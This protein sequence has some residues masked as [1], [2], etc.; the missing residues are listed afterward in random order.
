MSL[1]FFGCKRADIATESQTEMAPKSSSKAEKESKTP[2]VS[3]AAA[4]TASSK[5][6]AAKPKKT[7][8]TV[9]HSPSQKAGIAPLSA[10]GSTSK[11]K[12][13]SSTCLDEAAPAA[14]RRRL[15]RRDTNDKVDRALK[16][17]AHGLPQV[18]VDGTRNAEG[19]TMR[20]KC[21]RDIKGNDGK[22]RLSSK[23][24]SD[25]FEEFGVGGDPFSALK[26]QDD[27]QS[28]SPAL[29]GAL[30]ALSQRNPC[31][32]NSKPLIAYLGQTASM[33]QREM[34]GMLRMVGKFASNGAKQHDP[35]IL[36]VGAFLAKL[37]GRESHPEACACVKTLLDSALARDWQ[38]MRRRRVRCDTFVTCNKDVMQILMERSDIEAILACGGDYQSCRESVARVCVTQIGSA[39]Y[40]WTFGSMTA[41]DFTKE[42]AVHLEQLEHKVSEASINTCRDKLR[43]AASRLH[44]ADPKVAMSKRLISIEYLG[45][46][47]EVLAADAT[48]EWVLRLAALLKSTAV[49]EG[50]LAPTFVESWLDLHPQRPAARMSVPEHEL[51]AAKAARCLLHDMTADPSGALSFGKLLH[52]VKDVRPKL[53]ST[54]RSFVIECAFMEAAEKLIEKKIEDHILQCLPDEAAWIAISQAIYQLRSLK[55]LPILQRASMA[56]LGLVDGIIEILVGMDKGISPDAS[57]RGTGAFL[58]TVWSRFEYFAKFQKEQVAAGSD[59]LGAMTTTGRAAIEEMFKALQGR[60]QSEPEKVGFSDLNELQRFKWLLSSEQSQAL[61]GW[62]NVIL[63]GMAKEGRTKLPAA[64]SSSGSK[65]KKKKLQQQPASEDDRSRVMS[66]FG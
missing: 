23:W 41:G 51:K 45:A 38:D 8:K 30:S 10:G 19:L 28:V 48:Q 26:V 7:L 44:E 58:N 33:S 17:H 52:I 53:I 49:I 27:T 55:Q 59:D 65:S 42:I 16:L 66:Y 12:A 40:S 36:S 13:Q 32:R 57:L 20:E 2:D 31:D 34:V 1:Q 39:L 43:S 47:L 6:S 61:H 64:A 18:A 24:W 50:G 37:G 56:S 14:K 9:L 3:A 4:T 62:T 22:G 46:T 15:G 29:A 25:T 5:P 35:L 60:M 54:D 21:H 11:G 63:D